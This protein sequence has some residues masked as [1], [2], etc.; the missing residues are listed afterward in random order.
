[1]MQQPQ[2]C[3]RQQNYI[4]N[5]VTSV[6]EDGVE[7]EGLSHLRGGMA[8]VTISI[9]V[10]Y[11]DLLGFSINSNHR[12]G[13]QGDCGTE[14]MCA[15]LPVGDLVQSQ[16]SYQMKR[17][18]ALMRIQITAPLCKEHVRMTSTVYLLRRGD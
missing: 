14:C 18:K 7:H 17:K 3:F 9:F 4:Q 16:N 8:T 15:F 2:G 5:V 12:D 11:I 1:M 10:G 6:R 13:E